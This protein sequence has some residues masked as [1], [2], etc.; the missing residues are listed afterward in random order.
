MPSVAFRFQGK[1]A[2]Q[3]NRIIHFFKQIECR[4][5][6]P[7]NRPT[8]TPATPTN[9]SAPKISGLLSDS[10]VEKFEGM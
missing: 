7:A 6:T 1:A 3:K 5:D 2:E 4:F 8:D 9:R 10:N